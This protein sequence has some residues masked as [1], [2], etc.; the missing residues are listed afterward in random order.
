VRLIPNGATIAVGGFVGIGHPEELT[1][2]IEQRFLDTG[3]P[4]GVTLVY[5]A[6]QGDARSRGL[7]H[8]AH[9]GLVKRVV[10]GHWNLAPRLGQ[11]ALDGKIEA[12]N[13][14]Q[15]V[16]TH[17]YRDIAA[18][19]PGSITHIGLQTFLDPRRGGGK[20]NANT[21]EDL[22]EVITLAGR[23][24]LFY[25]AFPIHAGLLRATSA[26]EHGNLSM[27]R[28]AVTLEMLSIAQA[29]RNC[30][31]VTIAQVER[32]VPAGSIDPKLVQ[33][34]GI[35]VDAVVV[36]RPDNHWQTFA[37]Q[38]NPAYVN[39]PGGEQV[40]MPVMALDESKVIARRAA[41][42]LFSGAIVNLGIGMPEGVALVAHEE[43]V[44]DEIVMTVEAGCVGGIPAGGMSFGAAS[45]PEAIVDQPYQFDFYD[46]GGLDVAFL[47]MAQVD[48]QGNVNV[49][50][51]GNRLMG[52]GGFV[53]ISQTAH[54]VIFCGTFSA[55]GM[56][57][58]VD[59]GAGTLAIESE[60]RFPK[61][62]ASVDHLTFNG[63]YAWQQGQN[64]LY[65]TERAVF[66]LTEQGLTLIEVAPGIDVERDII[67][68]MA[69]RPAVS[70]NLCIMEQRLF[71]A[72]LVGMKADIGRKPGRS[73]RANKR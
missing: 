73:R 26:D 1:A 20:L 37:E 53:N 30:G 6:G 42:E 22:I 5:A 48:A 14:P 59:P 41:S 27:E 51:L 17:L 55:G 33:V 71:R 60:G 64:V 19:R 50:R 9:D 3:E 54:T 49:S 72:T 36:A 44:L 39:P 32:I 4:H 35:L 68:R 65:V 67:A 15:G 46:G 47:G 18:G 31:G 8:L 2:A 34:P 7:N 12:Y 69:F 29:V 40:C 62:V 61:F 66:K 23:E 21:R 56:I 57:A 52:A 16:I 11:M 28:E 45:Y 63:A 70:A 38:F 24:W 25:H 10:G 43:G 13:L 58:H